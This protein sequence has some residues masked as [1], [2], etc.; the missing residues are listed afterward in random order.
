MST[1]PSIR[2]KVGKTYRTRDGLATVKIYRK[3]PFAWLH[4]FFGLPYTFTGIRM[5][6]DDDFPKGPQHFTRDGIWHVGESFKI[7]DLVEEVT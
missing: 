6:H 3:L 1:L 5:N 7:W 2:L 4:R